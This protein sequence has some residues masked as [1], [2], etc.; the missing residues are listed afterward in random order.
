VD[1]LLLL[2]VDEHDIGSSAHAALTGKTNTRRL[3]VNFKIMKQWLK[4]F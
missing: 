3:L 2:E 4:I 1:L